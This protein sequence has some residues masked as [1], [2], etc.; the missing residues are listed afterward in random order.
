MESAFLKRTGQWLVLGKG[1]GWMVTKEIPILSDVPLL[2]N[3]I[4]PRKSFTAQDYYWIPR[5]AVTVVTTTMMDR[6]PVGVPETDQP[7]LNERC[8]IQLAAEERGSRILCKISQVADD[9]LTVTEH[10]NPNTRQI[11]VKDV[12]WIQC[13]LNTRRTDP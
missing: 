3:L 2:G 9:A 7:P 10:G 12:L 8:I 6:D 11:P 5:D 4:T 13:L 1:V